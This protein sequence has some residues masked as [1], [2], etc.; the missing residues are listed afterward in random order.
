MIPAPNF[1]PTSD[2]FGGGSLVLNGPGS[3][4]HTRSPQPFAQAR[5]AVE[6]IPEEQEKGG[7]Q[8]PYIAAAA[9]S[10]C[11]YVL[12]VVPYVKIVAMDPKSPLVIAFATSVFVVC[13]N[14]GKVVVRVSLGSWSSL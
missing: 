3:G 14:S 8:R 10:I 4:R 2:R 9:L 1:G 13:M 6:T 11:L 5:T 12:S 7:G